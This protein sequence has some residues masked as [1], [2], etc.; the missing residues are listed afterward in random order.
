M[1]AFDHA[2]IIRGL[3]DARCTFYD[4]YVDNYCDEFEKAR[5]F[6]GIGR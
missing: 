5:L 3:F 2:P 1:N 4:R 6:R